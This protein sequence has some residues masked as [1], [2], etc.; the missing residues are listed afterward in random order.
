M[1]RG[2]DD[3]VPDGPQRF[4]QVLHL[5]VMAWCGPLPTVEHMTVQADQR[6]DG[7]ELVMPVND[8]TGQLARERVAELHRQADHQR[9]VRLAR[10]HRRGGTS[11]VG[12]GR[13]WLAG[14]RRGSGEGVTESPTASSSPNLGDA[15]RLVMT[16]PDV[17]VEVTDTPS[18][19][20]DWLQADAK[21]D[22]TE[23]LASKLRD[24]HLDRTMGSG[25]WIDPAD[26]TLE[27]ATA[28][29]GTAVHLRP[30]RRDEREL[31]ARFFAGLS[32][33]SRRRR[34][35]QP[36]PRLP[37]AMLRRLVE[38]DGRRHAAV[39]AEVHGQ[40]VGIASY[41][42]LADQ[43][44][45]AEVAVTVTDRYQGRG[46]GRLPV[47]ALRPL[48]VSAGLTTLVYL[49]DPTNW[50]GAAAAAVARRPSSLSATA[51]SRPASACLAGRC[52]THPAARV[53]HRADRVGQQARELAN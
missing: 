25:A 44:G 42:A 38:V 3:D 2:R 22:P 28:R 33:E 45:A 9:L 26:P 24:G 34:F 39:V 20:A 18:M 51:W 53:R 31:V 27:L 23:L 30:L 46:I 41:V 4:H 6:E 35:L 13:R 47:D 7:E 12:R 17:G 43:P 19:R 1:R 21:D 32:D 50:P 8:W 36:M 52:W 29:D 5:W 40:C 11:G 16:G 15:M 37:E 48:A 49:V 10:T 14:W